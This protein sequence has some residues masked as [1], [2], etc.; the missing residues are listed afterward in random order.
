MPTKTCPNCKMQIHEDAFI[1]PHCNTHFDATQVESNRKARRNAIPF[2]LGVIA[3]I[4]G[5]SEGKI[6]LII[7]GVLLLGLFWLLASRT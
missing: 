5:I 2:V 7:I 1:C 6:F 3:I 4:G